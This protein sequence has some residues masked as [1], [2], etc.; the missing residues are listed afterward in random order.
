MS[1]AKSFFLITKKRMSKGSELSFP[2][3]E[4]RLMSTEGI[5]ELE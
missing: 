5:I 3:E 2:I 4:C 1:N